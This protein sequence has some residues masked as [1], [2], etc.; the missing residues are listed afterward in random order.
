MYN[1]L[2]V[3]LF[4]LLVSI[5]APV[6]ALDQPPELHL[7]PAEKAWLQEH[8]VIPFAPDPFFP[9]I[10]FFDQNGEL[11]GIS[12]DYLSLI[13][14]KLGVEFKP[15][16]SKSW[17]E[18]LRSVTNGDAYLLSAHLQTGENDEDY[19]FTVPYLKF[20]VIIL[21]RE[22]VVRQ[23]DFGDLSGKSIALVKDYPDFDL[24]KAN[25]PDIKIVPVKDIVEGLRLTAFGQVDAI[26]VLQPVASYYLQQEGIANLQVVGVA[27]F[28]KDTSFAINKEHPILLGILDKAIAATSKAEMQ[29]IRNRWIPLKTNLSFDYAP[30]IKLSLGAGSVILLLLLLIIKTSKQKRRLK[31]EITIREQ[32]ERQLKQ[33]MDELQQANRQLEI[34]VITDPLTGAVNRRGFYELMSTEHSRIIRYGGKIALL[35]LDVDHFKK[36]NDTFG[37]SAGDKAL[38]K[39]TEI[40]NEVVRTIDIVSRIGGEEFAVLLP[41]TSADSAAVLAERIRNTVNNISIEIEEGVILNLSVSIGVASYENGDTP[42]SMLRKADQALYFAK[43]SGRNRVICHHQIKSAS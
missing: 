29:Q 24:I 26:P 18:A 37:H 43:N 31:Q 1:L 34:A 38:R 17:S 7:T 25:Y 11:A 12:G 9:P 28:W 33:V 41:S 20:P 6:S 13:G 30:L 14:D 42:D 4:M 32:K 15:V 23:Q 35:V 21:A 22:S 27:E 16:Q 10:E 19:Y 40:C 5:C 2:S 39:L 3:C 36:V 8:P